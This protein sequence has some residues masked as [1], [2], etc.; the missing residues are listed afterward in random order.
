[1]LFFRLEENDDVNH[2]IDYIRKNL[3]FKCLQ[4]FIQAS[5]VEDQLGNFIF[6]SI[7]R[8]TFKNCYFWYKNMEQ[9]L[10]LRFQ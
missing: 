9:K 5:S 4:Q 7:L 3:A 1:M 2:K 10:N 6:T 8:R